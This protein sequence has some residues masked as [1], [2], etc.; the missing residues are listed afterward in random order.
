[1]TDSLRVGHGF[2]D[3]QLRVGDSERDNAL[4]A[5]GKHY[6]A[7]RLSGEELDERIS[8]ALRA[9]TRSDLWALLGDL[10]GEGPAWP[11]P[12]RP[13]HEYWPMVGRV[14]GVAAAAALVVGVLIT[15]L[16]VVLLATMMAFGGLVWVVLLWWLLAGNVRRSCGYRTYYRQPYRRTNRYVT[17]L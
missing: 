6:A 17:R 15:L 9:R 3:G 8:A 10:P 13:R 2:G 12:R 1:M 7:G 14:L 5:L 4:A 11:R 16:F